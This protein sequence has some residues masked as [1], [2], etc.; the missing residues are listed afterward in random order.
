MRDAVPEV[1][2][3]PI[4]NMSRAI[5]ITDRYLTMKGEGSEYRG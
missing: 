4:L 2:P 1:P 5:S 3:T